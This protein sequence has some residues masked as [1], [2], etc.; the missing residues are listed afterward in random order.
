MAMTD[1]AA[2]PPRE[3]RC[4]IVTGTTAGLGEAVARQL[5]ARGWAVIGVARRPAAIADPRYHHIACDLATI[6]AGETD[7]A[8]QLAAHNER[9][10][11]ARVV[12][13]VNNAA[14]PEGL[15]PIARL[16]AQLVARVYAVNTIAPI[17]LM[18]Y[19]M[20]I[21]SPNAA[22]RIV[23]VSSGAATSGFPG[24]AAY[25]SSKAALRLAGM[26]LAREWDGSAATA[27]PNAALLS[28][29]PG[30]VDTDMQR[31]ARSRSP[32]EF[33]WVQMFL[34]FAA[35]GIA[36]PAERPATDI[37]AFVE[38]PSPPAFTE[39]RLRA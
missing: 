23:N 31:Y 21:A 16:E 25:G 19:V 26:S 17:W 5:L 18:G 1:P 27:R 33:P 3:D 2:P 36:V 35:R 15:M 12:A 11:G 20:R 28:Y 22:V 34:D 32:D 37:V 8:G 13:L 10:G 38:S 9:L 30:V 4:A 6:A 24:L 7:L 29:E 39:Q 14:A